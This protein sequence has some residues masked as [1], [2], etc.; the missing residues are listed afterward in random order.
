LGIVFAPSR[1]KV[2][3]EDAL[4]IRRSVAEHVELVGVFVAEPYELV[5]EAILTAGIQAVQFHRSITDIWAASERDHWGEL[6]QS[7]RVRIVRGIAARSAETLRSE[8]AALPLGIDQILLDAYVA[9][10][11]GG[12]GQTFEWPL[13]ESARESGLPIIVAGGLTPENVA[14]AV[15]ITRPWGVDVSSGVESIPGRKDAGA[16]RRFIINARSA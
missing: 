9:G 13:V 14:D 6:L 1:R 10:A 3:L 15:R 5:R 16:V 8:L 2:S 12:T 7:R 11:E 4:A